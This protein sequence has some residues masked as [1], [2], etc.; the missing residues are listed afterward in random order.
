MQR[1]VPASAGASAGATGPVVSQQT[2]SSSSRRLLLQRGIGV[3][4]DPDLEASWSSSFGKR[5]T[6]PSLLQRASSAAPAAP[7]DTATILSSQQ[8][9]SDLSGVTD[10]IADLIMTAQHAT[11]S[12]DR[13]I[14]ESKRQLQGGERKRHVFEE[15]NHIRENQRFN[16]A[17]A[18]ELQ[19]QARRNAFD[20]RCVLGASELVP[21]RCRCMPLPF[22]HFFSR[23]LKSDTS[24]S[25]NLEIG[26]RLKGCYPGIEAS[27]R[28]L[29]VGVTKVII[30]EGMART[31]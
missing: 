28:E 25:E 3:H 7:D 10:N 27:A 1:Q 18:E 21:A 13:T 5:A 29:S 15:E 2:G 8:Q 11:N 17:S 6:D 16:V 20:Q 19:L 14:D 23:P 30:L 9:S 4:D 24:S 31:G 22:C 12:L 26:L